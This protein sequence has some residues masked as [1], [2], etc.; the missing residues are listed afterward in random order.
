MHEAERP[1]VEGAL[2][3]GSVVVEDVAGLVVVGVVVVGVVVDGRV[4]GEGLEW[5]VTMNTRPMTM[6]RAAIE[7]RTLVVITST[8]TT[9][10]RKAVILVC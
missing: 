10:A 4:D 7:E 3:R 9:C 6:I 8:V 2:D 1:A 5:W